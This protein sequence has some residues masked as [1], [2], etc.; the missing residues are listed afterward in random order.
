MVWVPHTSCSK[1]NM[2]LIQQPGKE[3]LLILKQK[4]LSF[5][6]TNIFCMKIFFLENSSISFQEGANQG[7][8]LISRN[9]WG[10]LIKSSLVTGFELTFQSCI[11]KNCVKNICFTC[12]SVTKRATI[13]RTEGQNILKF[14]SALDILKNA[15]SK[16]KLAEPL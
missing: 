15:I 12:F 8:K 1:C 4:A 14:L 11:V 5:S 3:K 13:V 9:T 2:K 16:C 6:T 7:L 10:F